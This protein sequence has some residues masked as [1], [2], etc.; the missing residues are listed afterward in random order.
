L[1]KKSMAGSYS[2]TTSATRSRCDDIVIDPVQVIVA[3]YAAHRARP[4]THREVQM[5]Q[6]VSMNQL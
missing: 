4:M 3:F 1:T 2:R 6:E 5:R